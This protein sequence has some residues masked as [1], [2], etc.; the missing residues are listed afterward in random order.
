MKSKSLIFLLALIFM[1]VLSIGVTSAQDAD[2]VIAASSDEIAIGNSEV[3]SGT[4]SG[5]VDVATENPWNTT[6]E[7]TYDIPSDAKSIQSADVYVNVYGGSAKNTHGANANVTITTQNDVARYSESLWIAEGSTD[8]VVYTVNDHTTKCYS[9]YMI[10]YNVTNMLTGLNGT[11]LKVNVDTF[12]MENK[13]F[14]GR[15]KLIGLV[16]AYDDGSN[17][18]IN[19]WINDNQMWTNSNVTL[20]FDTSALTEV[21]DASL[22]N[23]ALSSSE[24]TYKMNGEFL[25]ESPDHKSGNY[26]QYNKWDV[27]D[28]IKN[29]TKTEFTAIGTAGSYGVSYKNVL[30]VLTVKPGIIQSSVS[31][32][33]ERANNGYTIVYPGTYNQITVTANTNKKG[34]YTIELL[35]DGQVVNTTEVS[36]EEG[37]KSVNVIDPTIREI[38]Q[39]TF[40]VTGG[41]FTEVNY[42]ARLLLNDKVVN[43]TSIKATVL[44]N[45]YF[46]KD[47][48]FPGQD[49]TSFLNESVTGG[50]E[51]IVSDAAYASGT[52]N[53]VDTWNVVLPDNS[54][55]AKAYVY[56]G[57]CYGGADT[58]DLFNVTFN[59][60]VPK[61]VSFTRDQANIVSTSGYGLIVYD[62]SDLIKAGEN[63]F[64]LNKTHSTGAYPS[65]LIY[66]YNTEGS[67]VV[68]NVY[69]YNG[70]DIIGVTGNG[71][72]RN[73]SMETSL[74]IDTTDVKEAVAYIFGAGSTTG[75][76]TISV[77]G[78]ENTTAWDTSASNAINVYQTDISKTLKD[79]NDVSIILNNN[80]FTTLQQIIV[81]TQKAK[82]SIS[83]P[84]S[85]SVVYNVNKNFVITLKD[86]N[87]NPIAGQ[88]VTVVL[89]KVAK[90]IVTNDKGQATYTA[91]GSLVPKNYYVATISYE[92][93]GTLAKSSASTK[94]VVKK[95]TPKVT[96]KA[97]TFKVKTKTKKYS[98]TLKNNKNK[99]IK[100]VKVTIKVNK[101][102]YT[103]KTNSKGVATFKINKLTK[104]GK[105]TATIKFAGNK[106]Y[107]KLTKKA[108]ITV[109][110]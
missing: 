72:G 87:G 23:I 47:L 75:R 35:A 30:S 80:M 28:N 20:T 66:L 18:I 88:N 74:K 9:D 78:E 58:I 61:A 55:F 6:G 56:V 27:T 19:Y 104:V 53:R 44:F 42:T 99:A 24:A 12:P 92:G 26:Y 94:V 32:V 107:N 79:T 25:A 77:N 89:N 57:Y 1:I 101:K 108:K 96:A 38:N 48:S 85:V 7:L 86:S 29:A 82:T 63:T 62:V 2:D 36:L 98:I 106:Y 37:S 102:T 110:K 10:H 15:I 64:T 21:L 5:G 103:A 34:K 70:A 13:S 45:G 17:S 59:G 67:D 33:T 50:F 41:N 22:T 49:Y 97:K 73:I 95:A 84:T 14:D 71:A 52:T 68:K 16:L 43:E 91:S 105:H 8:G 4:V 40:F 46:S 3:V 60:D 93:N 83:A 90:T 65:T 39:A 69:I 31:I 11:S 54:T 76:A 81:T 100:S 51:Y 109:K